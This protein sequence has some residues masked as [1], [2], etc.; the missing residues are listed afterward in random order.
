MVVGKM[1]KVCKVLEALV[2]EVIIAHLQKYNLINDSQHGF[3]KGRS[4]LTN[5]LGFFEDV[6][7]TVDKGE[8]V[9]VIYLD[10]QKASDKM[11]HRRLMKKVFATGIGGDIYNWMEDW[12]RDRKQRVCL[13]CSS[14]GWANVSSGVPQGSVLGPLLF[15]IYINDIDN[16][17]ASKILKFADDTKLYR[18]VG[19][20]E[21]IT[22]LRN[23]LEKLVGWSEEWLM[24]LNVDKCKV[25]HIGFGN[26][27]AG[28]KMDGFQLQEVHE[29]M[30]L[31]VLVQDKLK[32]AQQCAK[33][34]G[35]G[36]RVLGMIKR[37]FKNLSS[38]VVIKLYKCLIRPRLEYAVQAWS[39][40]LQKDIEL[41][42][43]VQRRQLN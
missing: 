41:I 28:Y 14:S 31:G 7:A 26:G 19:T 27:T 23:D 3:L 32:C 39:L 33:V 15:L 18:Q 21:D 25:M 29:E 6:T 5:L 24:L 9:D 12:L 30:D 22:I 13:K 20:A 2:K 34:V 36:N 10:F 37:T 43:G 11:P 40:N 4:C 42:E 16:G 38:N 8:P 35:K 17:I 1:D